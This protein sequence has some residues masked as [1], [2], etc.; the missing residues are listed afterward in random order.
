MP[1]TVKCVCNLLL[2]SVQMV[3]QAWLKAQ[4]TS[5]ELAELANTRMAAAK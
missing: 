1:M 5:L 3:D 4:R 2:A